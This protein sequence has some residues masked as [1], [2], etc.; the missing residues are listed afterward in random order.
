MV[1]Y[2]EVCYLNTDLNWN[3]AS[4]ESYMFE[5]LTVTQ[6]HQKS[7]SGYFHEF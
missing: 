2:A 3:I 4:F 1:H 5:M 7:S 6:T